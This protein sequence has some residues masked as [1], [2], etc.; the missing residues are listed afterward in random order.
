[1]SRMSGVSRIVWVMLAAVGASGD[2]V[3]AEPEAWSQFRGANA[4]GH[5]RSA[6]PL[7][8]QVGPDQN[9]LW[10]VAVPPGHSSPIVIGDH[11]VLT[12]VRASRLVT[13]ALDR[14]SGRRLWTRE[15]PH[16]TLEQIHRIGSH[17][18][19]SPAAHAGRIVSFFGSAGLFCYDLQGKL[20]WER[21]MGPYS[22]TYG[23]ACSPIIVDGRVILNQ[24]HDIDSH[25]LAVDL[26]TGRTVWRT[27]RSEFPRGYCTPI[28]WDNG[29]SKQVIVVGALRVIGYDAA[30]GREVWTVRGLARISNQTPVLGANNMLYI[31]EW[32]PGGDATNRISAD[33]WKDLVARHDENSSRTLELSELPDGPLKA[34]FPQIDRD[35]DQKIAEAEYVWM[36]EIFNTAQNAAVAIKLGGSGD[37]TDTHVVWR[38]RKYLPYVPSPLYADGFLLTVKDGGIVVTRDAVTGETVKR[39]RVPHTAAYYS[40]PVAG[41]GRVF[42]LSQRGGLTVLSQRADWSVLATA[43]FGEEAYATPAIVA[44]RLYLRTTGHLY[45][46]GQAGS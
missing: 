27:D 2:T 45:C 21:R 24:D 18:Q 8:Q 29:G 5:A 46:I 17:A 4:A 11:V 14:K 23:A 6:T 15:A 1:M 34:R 36:R 13:M 3:A 16:S 7:P 25:L 44:G 32:A 41:D 9:V 43:D 37:V 35:K 42:L 31:T 10:K 33:P 20:L 39:G 22:N 12:A 26:E 30:S 28:V 40:S 19:P 38:E